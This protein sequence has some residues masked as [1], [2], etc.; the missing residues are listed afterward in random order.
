MLRNSR[1][2]GNSRIISFNY[3]TL[4]VYIDDVDL[5]LSSGVAFPMTQNGVHLT[6]EVSLSGCTYG[7]PWYCMFCIST[8]AQLATISV[9]TD[10]LRVNSQEAIEVT[11][12]N[13]RFF[14]GDTD[15]ESKLQTHLRTFPEGFLK[16]NSIEVVYTTVIIYSVCHQLSAIVQCALKV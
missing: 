6:Y 10:S 13:G 9:G 7:C 1:Y 3:W 12:G 2:D 15:W 11:P 5:L 14:Y 4:Q 8:S 16:M